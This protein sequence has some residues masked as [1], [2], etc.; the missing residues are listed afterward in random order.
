VVSH[1][2]ANPVVY[3]AGG[4]TL[5]VGRAERMWNSY[6]SRINYVKHL[7]RVTPDSALAI[8]VWRNPAAEHAYSSGATDVVLRKE[9][10]IWKVFTW[11]DA[12]VHPP[13]HL[14]VTHRSETDAEGW[15]TLFDGKST[16]GWTALGGD[17]QLPD[18]W[19]IRDGILSAIQSPRRVGL[20]S[21]EEFTTFELR[22]EWRS[23]AGANSGVLYQLFAEDRGGAAGIEYQ[24]VDDDGD[25]GAKVDDRQKSGAQYGVSPVLQLASKPLGQWNGSRILVLDNRCEH[26]LNGV[27]TAAFTVDAIFPS[28]ISLQHHGPGIDFRNIRIRP[29]GEK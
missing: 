8:L 15:R 16:A 20:R 21:E 13:R 4:S 6:K 26:W 17:D 1:M 18:C 19:Q 7:V 28:P 29:L 24:I 25:P 3:N 22:F 27:K 11:R 2:S 14:P 23:A 12:Y 9:G 5:P 10:E